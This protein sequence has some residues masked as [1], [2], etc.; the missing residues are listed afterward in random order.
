MDG[1]NPFSS[2]SSRYSYWLVM[3]ITYNLPPWLCMK[4]NI[5]LTLLILGPKQPGNDM[6]IYLQ[7]L[8]EDL[9]ELWKWVSCYDRVSKMTFNLRVILMWTINDFPAYGNLVG[10][11]TKGKTACLTC[12]DNTHGV[13]LKNSWKFSYMG[14]RR[15]L[16]SSHSYRKKKSW[17]DEK[18]EKRFLPK[19][20]NGNQI[21]LS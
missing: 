9:K 15:F 2:L 12:G 6:D 20:V 4:K 5:M 16:P 11:T 17:F 14:H 13:W 10:C 18:V 1:F 21:Y 3:L 7:P 8:I 19:L